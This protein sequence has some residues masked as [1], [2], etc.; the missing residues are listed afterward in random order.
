MAK[1]VTDEQ[2]Q[3]ELGELQ[4]HTHFLQVLKW[5][6]RP[7]S[8]DLGEDFIVDIYDQGASA[9]LAFYVQ[10][11]S[12]A[13]L[14]KFQ[15]KTKDRSFSY[16]ICI[17]D[18]NHWKEYIPPVVIVIWDTT[19]L[20]GYWVTVADVIRDLDKRNPGW[21]EKKRLGKGEE[22]TV[23]VLIPQA[24]TLTKDTLESLRYKIALPLFP[25]FSVGKELTLKLDLSFPKDADGQAQHDAFERFVESGERVSIDGRFIKG[26]QFS[27]WFER[28][29]GRVSMSPQAVIAMGPRYSDQIEKFRLT[30]ISLEGRTLQREVIEVKAVQFGESQI[31]FS[32][33]HLPT[34][35]VFTLTFREAEKQSINLSLQGAKLT[36]GAAIRAYDFF[37]NA[38]NG[39]TLR[40]EFMSSEGNS[41]ST[42]QIEVP[43]ATSNFPELGSTFREMLAKLH[44]IESRTAV[45]FP[46]SQHGFTQDDYHAIYEV[47]EILENGRVVSRFTRHEQIMHG[48]VE[49]N[50]AFITA[51]LDCWRKS[52][53][54]LMEAEV[55]RVDAHI[56][57]VR[58]P[59][60]KLRFRL[61]GDLEADCAKKLEEIELS[62]TTPDNVEIVFINGEQ[63]Q[64]FAEWMVGTPM[65]PPME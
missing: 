46:V 33:E 2:E 50:D 34:P 55:G 45:S 41:V 12:S 54:M 47:A 49:A 23:N 42:G 52:E 27:D 5:K 19:Q 58:V 29:F 17:K 8:P 40:V 37:E 31:T 57:G 48:P 60:G 44:S 51:A 59:L 10:V 65:L 24:N 9:G 32:N 20:K 7:L 26:M 22:P 13:N 43:I 64:E 35:F 6:P 63:E 18:L 53:P 61:K 62:G 15:L 25:S 36:A 38:R 4:V 16:P 30:L 14:P 3:G 21:E 28:K 39:G 56:L 1:R 11:K